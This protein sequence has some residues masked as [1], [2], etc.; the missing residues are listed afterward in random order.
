MDVVLQYIILILIADR[1]ELR[2]Y[3]QRTYVDGEGNV[4]TVPPVLNLP[5]WKKK[6]RIVRELGSRRGQNAVAALLSVAMKSQAASPIGKLAGDLLAKGE[7]KHLDTLLP[8]LLASTLHS[9]RYEH[10]KFTQRSLISL[11]A[12]R[13]L[14]T[15]QPALLGA[16]ELDDDIW[17]PTGAADAIASLGLRAT[18]A[19]LKIARDPN[20]D[21]YFRRRAVLAIGRTEPEALDRIADEPLLELYVAAAR[22]AHAPDEALRGRILREIGREHLTDDAAQLCAELGI[23]E[24]L[25]ALETWM[26]DNPKHRSA[27]AVAEAIRALRRS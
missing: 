7:R 12:R 5:S 16:L 20:A 13:K 23:T 24:A 27:P 19:L 18:G 2:R 26:A 8:A 3:L 4:E 25:P 15:V 10:R 11:A 17:C 9:S 6:E 14:Q 22:Y 21:V 1:G